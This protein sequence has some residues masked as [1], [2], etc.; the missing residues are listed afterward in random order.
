VDATNVE[1]WARGQL[2]AVAR[3]ARRPA[4]AI[5]LALPMETCLAR[6]LAR[7]DARPPAA[8]R[9]QHRWMLDSVPTLP[10][11]GFDRVCVL[12]SEEAVAAIRFGASAG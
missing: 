12:E 8:I 2:L 11:E 4:L 3:R 1:R 7:P 10:E 5:V 6:N 9:R